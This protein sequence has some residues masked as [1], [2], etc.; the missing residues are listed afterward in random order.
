LI[1]VRLP[2]WPD[3][4]AESAIQKRL[5]YIVRSSAIDKN[6]I[7]GEH[8]DA[9]PAQSL[10]KADARVFSSH[11]IVGKLM[12]WIAYS[13]G[14]V[15]FCDLINWLPILFKEE[16]VPAQQ[17]TLISALFPLGGFGA[18]FFGWLMDRYNAN[19]ETRKGPIPV[20]PL[21]H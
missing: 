5:R 21:G 19:I 18:I 13:M 4:Y 12:L 10:T 11:F 2:K 16:G 1:L 14:L 8:C 6:E 20:E 3:A 15:I 7:R 17:A 9:Y